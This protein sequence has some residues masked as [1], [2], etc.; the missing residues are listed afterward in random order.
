MFTVFGV[1]DFLPSDNFT[2]FIA[3]EVCPLP[4][5]DRVCENTLFLIVGFDEKHL[6]MVRIHGP[7]NFKIH[8]LACI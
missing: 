7:P 6:N 4:L 8:T 3:G 2:R 5:V 1:M